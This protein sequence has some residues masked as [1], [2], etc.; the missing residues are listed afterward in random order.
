MRRKGWGKVDFK[1]MLSVILVSG[2]MFLGACDDDKEEVKP[3]VITP[4]NDKV[5]IDPTTT[6][7]QMV[8]FG[9]ALSWYSERILN[10][11]KKNEIT[12][13]I[14]NDLGA[15]ILRLKNWYYPDGYPAG[16]TTDVMTDDNSKMLW[17][18]TNQ[19]YN[20]AK[21][22][23]PNV[24]VLLSSW[25]PPAN[26]KSNGSTRE[27]TLK[28]DNGVFMYDAFATYWSDLLDNLPFNPDY[29]SI[30]NEP[31]YINAGWTTSQWAATDNGTLPGYAEAFDKVYDQI[32]TRTNPPAMIGPESANIAGNTFS[33][34]ADALKSKPHLGMY[35]YHPYNFGG[36]TQVSQTT[37][38]L[39]AVAAY[40]DKP[41]IMTEYSDTFSW[42]N[43]ADFINNTLIHANSSGYIY[44]KLVW[45][46]PATGSADAGMVSITSAG[47]YTVTPFYYVMKHFA[48]HV[49]AGYTR[50]MATS[51]NSNLSVS[52]FI[53][54]AQDKLAIIVI[55]KGSEE[56]IEFEVKDKTIESISADQ[57][58]EGSYYKA[59]DV[60]DA[61]QPVVLPSQS[62]TTIVL[63]I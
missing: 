52:A 21:S 22:G 20:L 12:Q 61:G 10:S 39:K 17:D 3:P 58:K 60:T 28:K 46:A 24:K 37:T 55:N 4:S 43:T 29:I 44:W 9:G 8:G 5:T 45:A 19:L 56:K 15:D 36:G 11:S 62:V 51:E 59:L 38:A 63:D 53:N 42:L 16:K 18:A 6:Y 31:S 33:A 30:Q 50:V 35:A 47:A 14:F 49:D 23:N 41:N 1:G 32:K 40:N 13:L 26:L 34:F 57:S 48:K 54:P 2:F 7:Q 27:G 25:G